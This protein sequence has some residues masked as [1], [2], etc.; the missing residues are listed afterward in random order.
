M[1]ATNIQSLGNNQNC[2]ANQPLT[3]CFICKKNYV[4]AFD[5]LNNL[6]NLPCFQPSLFC[7]QPWLCQCTVHLIYTIEN[8]SLHED[9]S[10]AAAEKSL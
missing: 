4:N 3:H 5:N 1:A 8:G 9:F 7:K 2:L 6:L 10:V